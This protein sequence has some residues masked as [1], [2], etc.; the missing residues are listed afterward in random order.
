[1]QNPRL[2]AR[3]AKSLLDLTREQNS[4]DAALKD[5]Q[6]LDAI[7][8]QNPD[9]VLMLRSPVIHAD[10]KLAIIQAV[11]GDRLTPL[12]FSFVALLVR[13]GRESNLPEI[14]TAFIRQYKDAHHIR[15]VQ[16]TT[17]APLRA[18]VRDHILKQVVA[19]LQNDRVELEEKVDPDLIGGFVLEMDDKLFD[20]SIL[21]DLNTVKMQFKQNIYVRNIR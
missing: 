20:A 1:M 5:M 12:T 15:S 8:R 6:L 4:M 2:A 3:Y 19:S 14:A 10:K 11:I 13:K 7:C 17:A 16:L 9:F 18:D 21:H